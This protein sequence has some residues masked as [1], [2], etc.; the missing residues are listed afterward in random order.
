M[1]FLYLEI[2][3]VDHWFEFLY[4][5]H[6]PRFWGSQWSRCGGILGSTNIPSLQLHFLDYLD[7]T[8]E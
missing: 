6:R 8:I 3:E 2:T 5:Q 1:S 4:K 7:L